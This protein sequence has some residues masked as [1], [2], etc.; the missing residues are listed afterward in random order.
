MP[1]MTATVIGNSIVAAQKYGGFGT[2]WTTN[3]E[4]HIANALAGSPLVFPR[5]TA[6]TRADQ[7]AVY[8]Y[9]GQTL[10][11]I[12]ADLP[13]QL[14]TPLATAAVSPAIVIGL[15]LLENDIGQ[16]LSVA[17]MQSDL[18]QFV[19]DAQARCP[20]AILLLATPRPSFSYNTAAKVA[21]YQAMRDYTLAL[22][23]GVN[24]FVARLD[25]YEN[26]AS[27]GTPLG[28]SGAPI[29]TDSSVHPNGR[30]TFRNAR[31]LA[32][33]LRRIA[34]SFKQAYRCVGTNFAM[35]GTAAATGTNVSGTVP[36]SVSVAGSSNGT[37]ACTAEQPG[38]L[39]VITA[40]ASGVEPPVDLSG[41]NVGSVA[42]SG[43]ASTQLSPFIELEIVSGAENLA[44]LQIEPRFSGST[45]G[46]VLASFVKR[47][48]NNVDPEFRNGDVLLFRVPPLMVGDI[49]GV[50]GNFAGCQIYWRAWPKITGRTFSFRVKSAGVGI[51]VP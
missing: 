47:N 21:A 16:G 34:S 5:I 9:S 42:I 25:T 17:A 38:F 44:W 31:V 13:A 43:G 10:P 20:G 30:G 14:W 36:T 35:V 50:V 41:S 49:T 8:G 32:S 12:N 45:S 24:V 6:S 33:T 26:P 48:N 18:T 22:D 11:T 15:A 19:R 4:I 27:P 3:A 28:T 37:Y 2:A 51:V 40:N 46:N 23:N 7:Y 1:A 29:F 39:Q